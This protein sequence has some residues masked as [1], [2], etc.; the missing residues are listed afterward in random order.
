MASMR[1]GEKSQTTEPLKRAALYVR[2][3]SDEQVEGF[4]L[5]AQE[6]AIETFCRDH[7]YQIIGRYRDEGKSAR[8]DDLAKRP[9]FQR[10]LTHAD[11][12]R[13]DTVIVHKLDRFAR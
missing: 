7:G 4:S 11:E 5:D 8:T 3:S 6:R 12:H 13:F 1:G 9:A 2:V 10:M